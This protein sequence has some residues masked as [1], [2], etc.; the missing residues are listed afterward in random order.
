VSEG[1]VQS[2]KSFRREYKKEAFSMHTR[3]TLLF[4]VLLLMAP[5]LAMA[6]TARLDGLGVIPGFVDDYANIFTY[7]VS[8]T[9]FPGVVIGEL[10]SVTGYEGLWGRGF[11]MTLGLGKGDEYGVFGMMLRENAWFP[12]A[13]DVVGERGTQFDLL[14]GMNFGMAS[15]GV[16]L[17]RTSS[18]LDIVDGSTWSPLYLYTWDGT[19][20]DI[21]QL[22][23]TGLAL[24]AAI[25]VRETDR[26]EATF[27]YRTL[28][29][30]LDKVIG[31]TTKLEDKGQP[32]YTVTGRGFF[33]LAENVTLVPMAEYTKA[34]YSW[35]IKSPAATNPSADKTITGITAGAGLKIDVGS[36]FMFGVG[37][38]QW[39]DAGD[40]S[41]ITSGVSSYEIKSTSLPFLFGCLEAPVKDWLT[42]RFG[43][44]KNLVNQDIIIEDV[45]GTKYELKSKNGIIP[46]YDYVFPYGEPFLFSMG[47][48]FKFGDLDIDATLND[49]YPFTGMYWLSGYATLPFGRISATYHY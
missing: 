22:N 23:T 10:G 41:G 26:L 25:N 45:G 8:I 43:A 29:F 14:W 37:V 7:P 24:S 12:P 30:L 32:S 3:K 18:Q 27:E 21:N 38:S 46:E 16:R 33:T 17:D 20:P 39:K 42:V 44:R 15:F 28:D 47:L 1:R 49:N 2:Q 6:S 19:E 5:A 4:T 13:P 11:G 40:Y 36:F 34:D 35:E 48:G 31:A 9:R